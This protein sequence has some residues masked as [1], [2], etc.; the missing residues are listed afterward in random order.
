MGIEMA[1]ERRIHG[2]ICREGEKRGEKQ[3]M[4]GQGEKL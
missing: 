2:H 1:E 3:E 4:N